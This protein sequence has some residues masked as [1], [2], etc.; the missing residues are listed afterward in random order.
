MYRRSPPS[1]RWASIWL[2]AACQAGETGASPPSDTA[3]DADVQR[4]NGSAALCARPLDDVTFAV[5]HN[6]MA[7]AEEDWWFPNQTHAVPRQ[8]ADGIRGISFDTHYDGETAM[9]CHSYCDLGS[10]PLV[11]GLKDLSL[12]HI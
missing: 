7:S 12:I 11:D 2:L 4:C 8:L 9:L 3:N 6:A 1:F 5:T 10:K